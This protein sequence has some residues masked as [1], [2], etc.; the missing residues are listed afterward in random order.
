MIVN[1][2]FSCGR[3]SRYGYET[4]KQFVETVLP[5]K[6][7][8]QNKRNEYQKTSSY[9]M[10]RLIENLLKSRMLELLR[11]IIAY[12]YDLFYDLFL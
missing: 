1:A 6:I 3:C 5:T 4:K 11:N 12:F 9:F 2:G 8:K 10:P 7:N